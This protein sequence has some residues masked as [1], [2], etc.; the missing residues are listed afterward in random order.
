MNRTASAYLAACCG[1]NERI[2]IR[3]MVPCGNTLSGRRYLAGKLPLLRMAWLLRKGC[4]RVFTALSERFISGLAILAVV[5]LTGF[6]PVNAQQSAVDSLVVTAQVDQ[7]RLQIGDPFHYSVIAVVPAG[8]V[9]EWPSG[10]NTVGP[11]ELLGLNRTGPT[12]GLNGALSDTLRHTLTIY[13]PGVY[14]L[15]AFTL[16]GQVSGG[17]TLTATTDSI[18]ITVVSVIEDDPKDIRDIKGPVAIPAPTPWLQWAVVAGIVLAVGLLLYYLYRRS[19]KPKVTE[20]TPVPVS[21]RSAYELAMEELD[22]LAVSALLAD[23]KIK[24][25]YTEL[26]EIFRRYLA[27]KYGVAAMEITTHELLDVLYHQKMPYEYRQ[28]IT[29]LLEESDLVKFAKF[30]PEKEHQECSI[31]KA[32]TLIVDTWQGGLVS[33]QTL[34]SSSPTDLDKVGL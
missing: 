8:G 33:G 22:R 34:P 31:D 18:S 6:L 4:G 10:G 14:T 5:C 20:P 9:I 7:E 17:R 28:Q 12:A 3:W 30:V 1:V 16:T 21:P 27:G 19:K 2:P 15:P 13:T 25:H 29:T 24:Q 26:S 11:F 32:R 23:G